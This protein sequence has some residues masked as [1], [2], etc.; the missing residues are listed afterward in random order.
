LDG[1]EVKTMIRRLSGSLAFK[2]TVKFFIDKLK[3]AGCRIAGEDS[4]Q[5]TAYDEGTVVFEALRKGYDT[6]LCIFAGSENITWQ[7]DE[8]FKK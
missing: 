5:V 3:F 8:I 1:E 4:D 6:W 2:V 7:R